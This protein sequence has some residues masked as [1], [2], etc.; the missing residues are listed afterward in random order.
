M[1]S[2]TAWLMPGSIGLFLSTGLGFD[3]LMD[4]RD[5]LD[6]ADD[7]IT[8]DKEAEWR[9]AVSRAYFASFHTAQRLL[10][11]CGFVVPKGEQAHAYLWLRLANSAH[12]DVENAGNDLNHLRRNRNWADYVLDQPLAFATAQGF[13]Q[14]ADSIIQLL[15]SVPTAPSVQAQ[16]TDAIKIYERDILRQ[17]TWTS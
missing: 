14:L 15:E 2:G 17:V 11:K 9:S 7:L 5:F 12:P 3:F 1:E 8:G 10:K 6:V 16:I 4:P 13:V